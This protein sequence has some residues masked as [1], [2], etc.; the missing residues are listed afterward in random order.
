MPL[1]VGRLGF[2]GTHPPARPLEDLVPLHR[3]EFGCPARQLVGRQGIMVEQELLEGSK[4]AR[5]ILV[6]RSPPNLGDESLAK[7]LPLVAVALGER[8]GHPEGAALPGGLEDE[9]AVLTGQTLDAGDPPIDLAHV[10]VSGTAGRATPIIVSR[11]TIA[12]SR[13]SAQPSV[14]A[15]RSGRTR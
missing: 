7:F 5:V 11:V 1:Q 3:P 10:A 15:G 14:P 2:P 12:A 13:S 6:V 9:L 4:P 8:D